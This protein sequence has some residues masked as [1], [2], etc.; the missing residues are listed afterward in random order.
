MIESAIRTLVLQ[1]SDITDEIGTRFYPLRL[2]QQSE[3]PACTFQMI[4]DVPSHNLSGPQGHVRT[5]LQIDTYA[6]TYAKSVEVADL[7]RKQIDGYAGTVSGTIITSVQ[8][9]SALSTYETGIDQY[10]MTTDYRIGYY[11]ES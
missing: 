5:L 2:P 9:A 6:A 7:I 1:A 3:I 10:R 4:A 11:E 8:R